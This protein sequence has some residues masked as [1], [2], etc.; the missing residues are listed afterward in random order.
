MAQP[1]KKP[2]AGQS[3][4][5]SCSATDCRHNENQECHAG[6]IVVRMGA[7]GAECGTYAPETPKAR[8]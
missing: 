1:Q 2:S 4:V 5:G 3:K 8:P 7:K 6:E